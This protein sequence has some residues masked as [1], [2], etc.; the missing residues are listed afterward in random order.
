MGKFQ[1]ELHSL[2]EGANWEELRLILTPILSHRA[3]ENA[4]ADGSES[5][6]Y[7]DGDHFNSAQNIINTNDDG[8]FKLSNK[9]LDL[10]INYDHNHDHNLRHSSDGKDNP[11]KYHRQSSLTHTCG[12]TATSCISTEPVSVIS[13]SAADES[14]VCERRGMSVPEERSFNDNGD[15]HNDGIAS[16][17]DRDSAEKSIV[18]E[19]QGGVTTELMHHCDY[20]PQSPTTSNTSSIRN[21]HPPTPPLPAASSLT[22]EQQ[23][24]LS[25]ER[26]QHLQNQLLSREGANRWT[27]LMIACACAPPSVISLLVQVCPEACGIPDRSG[28]LPL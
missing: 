9:N 12:T 19:Q 7:E 6:N 10:K 20:A 17:C 15:G 4:D 25:P 14:W 21:T 13:S 8:G 11:K 16:Q 5:D 1:G 24:K 27:P 23:D 18:Q 2:C 28:S 3:A 26:I 22:P